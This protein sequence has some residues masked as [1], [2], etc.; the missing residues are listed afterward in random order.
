M[1]AIATQFVQMH[2]GGWDE[3]LAVLGPALVVGTLIVI[4][5]RSRPLDDESDDDPEDTPSTEG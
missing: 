2:A 4:A 1:S 3:M 5:R